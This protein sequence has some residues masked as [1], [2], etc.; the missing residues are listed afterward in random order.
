MF[1]PVFTSTTGMRLQGTTLHEYPAAVSLE[2]LSL[3]S[4][5]LRSLIHNPPA[6]RAA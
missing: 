2:W 5:R 6:F 4:A 3:S 1:T